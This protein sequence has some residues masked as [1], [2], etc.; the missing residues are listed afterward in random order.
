MTTSSSAANRLPHYAQWLC[1][2]AI[3]AATIL[4][5]QAHPLRVISWD[6]Y[7]YYV[8]LPGFINYGQVPDYSFV[9]AHFEQYSISTNLYQLQEINP[10]QQSPKP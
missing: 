7:G 3:V 2:L 6:V 8:Y 5:Y 4:H 10:A 1:W 9:A